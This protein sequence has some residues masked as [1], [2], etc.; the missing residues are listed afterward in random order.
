MKNKIRAISDFVFSFVLFLMVFFSI[1]YAKIEG[2]YLPLFCITLTFL[3]QAVYL[4]ASNE[5]YENHKQLES[6]YNFFVYTNANATQYFYNAL[7]TRYEVKKEGEILSVGKYNI[8]I[9]LSFS[10]L[11]VGAVINAFKNKTK[12]RILFLCFDCDKQARNLCSR[13]PAYVHIMEKNEVF[14]LLKSLNALPKHDFTFSKKNRLATALSIAS[15]PKMSKGFILSACVVLLF[16]FISPFKTYYRIFAL[17]ILIISVA[18][19]LVL[20]ILKKRALL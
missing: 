15:A 10:P 20:L 1:G 3:C 11:S 12:D 16:S 5:G 6:I 18:Y 17:I 14:K 19:P 2:G 7:K 4:K 9:H 8:F 13:L